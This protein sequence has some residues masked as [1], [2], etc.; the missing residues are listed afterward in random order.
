MNSIN[1]V[2]IFDFTIKFLNFSSQIT[3][4]SHLFYV[5]SLLSFIFGRP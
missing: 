2:A 1:E 4:D 5:V 3:L